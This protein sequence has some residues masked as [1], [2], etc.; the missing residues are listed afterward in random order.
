MWSGEE[1]VAE[2]RCQNLVGLVNLTEFVGK[3]VRMNISLVNM[4]VQ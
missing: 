1:V 3:K 2:G 4:S